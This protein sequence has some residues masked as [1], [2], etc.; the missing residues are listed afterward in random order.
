MES[1]VCE[2]PVFHEEDLSSFGIDS[3]CIF[4][5]NNSGLLTFSPFSYLLVIGRGYFLFVSSS[6]VY[7]IFYTRRH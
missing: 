1:A 4:G 2:N 6:A 3:K 7:Y 5:R